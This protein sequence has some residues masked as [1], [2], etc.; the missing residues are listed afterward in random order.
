M[1]LGKVPRVLPADTPSPATFIDPNV[2]RAADWLAGGTEENPGLLVIGAPYAGGSISHARTDEAPA[3]IRRALERFT[4]FSSDF[5][6][7]LDR[8]NALDVGD[9]PRSIAV[10]VEEFQLHV[11]E[12]L[13]SVRAQTEAPI[14]VLGGDNSIT[15]GCHR[16]SSAEALITFDAHHDV[17]DPSET[18]PTNGSP[19]RQL[20]EGGLA[21][22]RIAQIGIHGFANA[23]PYARYAADA[24]INIVPAGTVRALGADAVVEDALNKLGATGAQSIWVDVDLDCLERALAPGAPAAMPGGLQPADLIRAAFRLGHSPLVTGLDITE[25][26]PTLDVAEATVRTACA[27]LLSFAAG[28]AIRA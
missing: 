3:A 1:D 4:T 28:V 2:R 20:I 10:P 27:V 26:D 14:A 17:R 18:G 19:V 13:R 7:S 22:S 11:E 24:G 5:D 21:G 15:V 16:G 9:L 12:V 25:F 23:E 6:T 8:L